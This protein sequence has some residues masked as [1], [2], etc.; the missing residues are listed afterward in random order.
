[1][2]DPVFHPAPLLGDPDV[3][4]VF[5][6]L[7]R[8]RPGP[9]VVRERWELPD[10]DFLDVDR[11]AGRG[12]DAPV[13]VLCH[14][15]EGDSRT[16]YIRGLARALV[17]RGLAVA[18]L[19]FRG[20][21][22]E[23]NRLLRSYHS[24]ETGDLAHAVER[25]SAERPG[26]PVVVAGFSLGGNV[27]T[28]WMGELG[29][30]AP[31]ALRGG[32]AVSVPFD[33]AAS[34]GRL[35]GPGT[36]TWVY[37]ERFLKRL[38]RKALEKARRFPGRL[39]AG[40]V[41]RLATFRAFDDLVTAPTHG[42]ASGADYYARCSSGPFVARIRLPFLLL[43]S[44]DDPMVPPETIPA[45]AA[46]RA[47]SVRLVVTARGGHTAFVDGSPLRPGFWAERAAADFL[48]GLVR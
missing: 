14:G 45:E 24:G 32:V 47:P 25:L 33:L 31:A 35:D 46:R 30:A 6:T 15:L 37:R 17:A 22:G 38:R 10:G 48:A 11:A 27:V 44:A 8:P 42:F 18:A 39:D 23:P 2:S 12:P 41:E 34:G 5:A 9:P 20:C 7:W 16:P 19:N 40:A 43:Q 3:Q 29:A 4:T 36:M 26:R 1:V 21:S 28:K 13:A